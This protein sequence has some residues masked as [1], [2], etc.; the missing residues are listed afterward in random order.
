MNQPRLKPKP[1]KAVQAGA[2]MRGKPVEAELSLAEPSRG[3]TKLPAPIYGA[4]ISFN[5]DSPWFDF[6][7]ILQS[8]SIFTTLRCS[9]LLLGLELAPRLVL[10]NGIKSLAR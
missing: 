6:I 8:E 10:H 4:V 5:S 7:S 1:A 9:T 3:N 2:E